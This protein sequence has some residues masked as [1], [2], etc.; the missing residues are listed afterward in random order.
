MDGQSYY[1]VEPC[2]DRY[3]VTLKHWNTKQNRADMINLKNGIV[4]RTEQEARKYVRTKELE[5]RMMAN[6]WRK[7]ASG[8]K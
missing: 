1:T 3:T 7:Y 8:K 6:Y 5:G 4:F 2:D